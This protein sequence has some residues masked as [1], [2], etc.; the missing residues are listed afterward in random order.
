MLACFRKKVNSHVK[1]HA[2]RQQTINQY[3]AV[4]EI[5]TSNGTPK[6]TIATFR[7]R[8]ANLQ[9]K[10]DQIDRRRARAGTSRKL[11][12]DTI[13]QRHSTRRNWC[14]IHQDRMPLTTSEC[15]SATELQAL[16]DQLRKRPKTTRV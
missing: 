8:L 3:Q 10:L 9:V 7:T 14:K 11:N 6:S 1:L 4:Q 12:I 5:V 13:C 16:I 15:K 2:L